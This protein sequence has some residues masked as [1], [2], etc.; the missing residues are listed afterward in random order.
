MK[1]RWFIAGFVAGVVATVSVLSHNVRYV[2][3]HMGAGPRG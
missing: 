1:T 3:M 2:E